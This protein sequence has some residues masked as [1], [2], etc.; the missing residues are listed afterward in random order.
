MLAH[1]WHSEGESQLSWRVP[2]A[3]VWNLTVFFAAY[4]CVF[5]LLVTFEPDIVGRA[6]ITLER[7]R[8]GGE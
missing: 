6:S 4:A 5:S 1:V 3:P 8:I 2:L 7:R